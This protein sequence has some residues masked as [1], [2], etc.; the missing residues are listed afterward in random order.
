VRLLLGLGSSLDP[1]RNLESACSRLARDARIEELSRAWWTPAV[2]GQ[3]SDPPFLNRVAVVATPLAPT[4]ARRWL[5]AI[6]H[7]HGRTRGD[8]PNAP[9]TLDIDVLAEEVPGTAGRGWAFRIDVRKE[10]YHLLPLSDLLPDLRLP[11]GRT[12]REQ[13]LANPLP[14]A[15]PWN[16][17]GPGRWMEPPA[18]FEARPSH[19]V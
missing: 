15:F 17:A 12:V 5:R 13:V 18:A 19:R 1:R 16:D 11:D 7:D 8:D 3:P 6:E 9:R 14:G 10:P 4:A 2:G